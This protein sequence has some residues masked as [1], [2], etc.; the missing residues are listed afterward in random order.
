MS[1]E[2]IEIAQRAL[3]AATRTPKPDFAVVNA[4]YDPE[5]VLVDRLYNAL[6]GER[7][8]EGARGYREHNEMRREAWADFLLR[9]RSARAI[10]EERVLLIV[11]MRGHG[12]ETG[13]PFEVER[14][15]LVT[16]RDRRVLRTEVYASP[17]EALRAAG[18][19]Q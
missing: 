7:A 15:F 3:Q 6:E 13:A 14:G 1:D 9:I 19:S 11:A 4:L 12:S 5:H 2:N 16:V 18:V 10:D 17:A 8:W